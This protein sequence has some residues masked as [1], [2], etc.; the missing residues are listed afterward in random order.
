MVLNTSFNENEPVVCTAGTGALDCFL[1]TRMDTAGAR[2]PDR[3]EPAHGGWIGRRH[4]VAPAARSSRE[5]TGKRHWP[6]RFSPPPRGWKRPGRGDRPRLRRPAA[7]GRD[8]PGRLSEPSGST[9]TRDKPDQLNRGHSYVDAVEG[10]ALG[11]AGRAAALDRATDDFA[12][13]AECDVVTICVPT[14]LDAASRAR[15]LVRRGH[16]PHHRP[17]P[18]SRPADRAGDRP[19]TPARRARWSSRCSSNPA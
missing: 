7:G 16:R 18:A 8:R 3:R 4:A 6:T 9:S 13:L 19:P 11:G 14:P 17:H 10:G 2:R 15:S 12:R 1:R 5:R